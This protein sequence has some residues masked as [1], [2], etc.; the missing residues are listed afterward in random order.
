MS[1]DIVGKLA[2]GESLSDDDVAYAVAHSIVLP[3]EYGEAE[4]QQRQAITFAGVPTDGTPV[5]GTGA[6]FPSAG[7]GP[8]LFLDPDELSALTKAELQ[9]LADVKGMEA[10]G[11][12]A[13][14]VASLTGQAAPEESDENDSDEG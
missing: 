2:K 14:I 11:T 10:S 12:K 4:N 6:A 5:Y 3:E 7:S 1:V 9:A 8:G 13:D